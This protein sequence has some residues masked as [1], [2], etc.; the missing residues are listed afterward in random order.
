M[1]CT[2]SQAE[3]DAVTRSKEID[4]TLRNDSRR[5]ANEVKLLLL[6]ELWLHKFIVI[7]RLSNVS[8]HADEWSS[9]W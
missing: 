9:K 6:G 4:R 8:S 2:V 3:K 7:Y 1:G 5:R